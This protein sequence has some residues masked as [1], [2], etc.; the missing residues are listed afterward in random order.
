MRT[1][2]VEIIRPD[3]TYEQRVDVEQLQNYLAVQFVFCSDVVIK[4]S[5]FKKE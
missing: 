4:L 3:K 5:D 1:V 2:K